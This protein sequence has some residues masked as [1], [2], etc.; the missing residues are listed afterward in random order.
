MPGSLEKKKSKPESQDMN[1]VCSGGE[2][3]TAEIV[4]YDLRSCG[5]KV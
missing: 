2:S 5:D 3:R 1:S 4:D